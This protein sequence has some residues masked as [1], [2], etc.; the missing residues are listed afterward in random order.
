MKFDA[1]SK[2]HSNRLAAEHSLN[3]LPPPSSEPSNFG[4][5]DTVDKLNSFKSS[6]ELELQER[7]N[8]FEYIKLFY[9]EQSE[10]ISNV[11][12]TLE[13]NYYYHEWAVLIFFSG[14]FKNH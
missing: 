10:T 3:S 7:E 5:V 14:D 6:L 1:A 8:L 9:D 11:N 2:A 12:V 13:V 4:L